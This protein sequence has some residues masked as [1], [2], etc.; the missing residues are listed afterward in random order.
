MPSTKWQSIESIEDAPIRK[1]ILYRYN[2]R[3]SE[4]KWRYRIAGYRMNREDFGCNVITIEWMV[5]DD[6]LNESE[7]WQ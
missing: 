3:D 7:Q 5:V 1:Y 4:D 2:Y 6:N